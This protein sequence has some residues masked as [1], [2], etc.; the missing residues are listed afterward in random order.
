V[1]SWWLVFDDI[2]EL[3]IV[4][5]IDTD[6]RSSIHLLDCSQCLF[7]DRVLIAV[8]LTLNR[9]GVW[10]HIQAPR[11]GKMSDWSVAENPAHFFGFLVVR[12]AERL[13]SRPIKGGYGLSR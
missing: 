9:Y 12:N 11:K 5:A 7:L 2:L 3:H 6:T 4:S 1:K 10:P 13:D 8:I